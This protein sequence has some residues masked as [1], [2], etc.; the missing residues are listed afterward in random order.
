MVPER[1]GVLEVFR[2]I[3]PLVFD[4]LVLR[5]GELTS[6]RIEQILTC[7]SSNFLL[8]TKNNFRL[9]SW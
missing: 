6:E 7:L 8:D 2:N 9:L 1:L 4:S 3:L 5:V